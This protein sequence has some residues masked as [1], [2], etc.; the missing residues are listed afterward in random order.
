MQSD[1]VTN[2][3]KR[4]TDLGPTLRGTM[5]LRHIEMFQAILQAGTLTDAASLLNISQPA[6]TKLLQQAERRLG[7]PLFIRAKGRLHLTPE[8]QL[9]KGQVEQVFSHLCDLQMLVTNIARADK[10]LLR[11]VTTPTLANAIIPQS[12]T[13][14]QRLMGKTSIEVSTQHSRELFKAIVLRE[15][16]IGFTL[17]ESPHPDVRCEPLCTGSLMVIAPR[18]TWVGREATLPM[19]VEALADANLVGIST[20][21]SL[22][23]QLQSY[24]E[25]L[26]PPPRVSIWVQTYQIARDLV[27]NGEGLALVDPFMAASGGTHIQA[28]PVEPAVPMTLYAAYRVDGPLNSVQRQFVQCM[29]TAASDAVATLPASLAARTGAA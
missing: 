16:D 21:D 3:H 13:R 2:I 27:S 28:R 14:L 24:L 20:A 26:S 5:H 7:F 23:R 1:K 25:Q 4:A 10:R 9:L 11:V 17:Q 18:G 15:S 6:A 22:G 12:I 19:P 8:S 29:R